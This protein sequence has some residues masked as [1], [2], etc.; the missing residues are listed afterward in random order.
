MAR[1]ATRT[2]RWAISFADLCLLLLGFFV[3]LQAQ[4][5]RPDR[6]AAGMRQAFGTGAAG[7]S[8][9]PTFPAAS[10]FQRD[11]A[12]L[13][14]VAAARFAKIGAE[15]RARGEGVRIVSEGTDVATQRFDRWELAAARTA[16]IGRAIRAGG[17]A[18]DRIDIAIPSTRS[19]MGTPG[20][21]VTIL[22]VRD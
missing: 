9:R 4:G 3:I 8:T 10:L 2:P 6:M 12:I 20:Q 21:M 17:V 19:Q 18:D 16:A 13:T 5:G 22:P 11:E 7:A 1:A 14:P 15:A